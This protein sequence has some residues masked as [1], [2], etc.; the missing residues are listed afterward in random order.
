MEEIHRQELAKFLVK[1]KKVT[2]AGDGKEVV[3]EIP[4][5]KKFEYNERDLK[6]EDYYVGFYLIRGFETVRFKGELIWSM[7]YG[8]GM[9][10]M[11]DANLDYEF[12]E[13][14]FDF[15]KETLQN[16]K[17]E[18]PFR[19]PV[20]FKQGKYEY[21]DENQGDIKKFD[22]L[23]TIFFKERKAH[24]LKYSGNIIIPKRREIFIT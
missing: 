15:L 22:G 10:S 3:S 13:E 14:T 11:I 12:A 7:S 19:G 8:W 9:T 4:G 6:Y 21:F 23:E 2:W 24:E 5:F 18:R 1:A 20:K 16:I 17:I